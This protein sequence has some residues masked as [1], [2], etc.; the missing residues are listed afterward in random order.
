MYQTQ[1]VRKRPAN[2]SFRMLILLVSI[3]YKSSSIA[4][5]VPPMVRDS[6][7]PRTVKLTEAQARQAIADRLSVDNLTY[8]NGELRKANAAGDTLI[9]VLS[10][11]NGDLKQQVSDD[12]ILIRK[13]ERKI[14]WLNV[15]QWGTI[16]GTI[17]LLIRYR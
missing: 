6:L 3:L 7:P 16:T 12:G 14:F 2:N 1:I 11:E 8:Q 13:Q 9:N 17:Y 4:C 10:S 15:S 5:T